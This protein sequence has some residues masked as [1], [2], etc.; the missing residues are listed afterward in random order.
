MGTG[1]QGFLKA[2][3]KGTL[4]S[5][6]AFEMLFEKRGRHL[7]LLNGVVGDMLDAQRSRLAIGM[8]LMGEVRGGKLC[9]LVH[10]LCDSEEIWR[11][12]GNPARDYGTLLQKDL[13]Y[14]PLY[15]R[16]NS[17]LHIST[18]G[19]LLSQI[20]SEI[21][22]NNPGTIR[23]IIFIGYSMGGLVVRSACHYGEAENA[24]WV[25]HVKKIF[26]LGTPHHGT[27][28]EKLG[29]LVSVILKKVPN[30]FTKAIA[31]LGNRRSAGIKDLRFGYLLD[32]DWQE[33][34]PDA[35]WRDN[36]HPVPLLKGVD[37]Y[38]ITATL[39]KKSN[40]VF[41]QYFGDGLVS[42]RS[43]GGR[44][45]MKS[46]AISFPPG[47]FKTLRGLFHMR[48][49]HHDKVYR[50][51]RKWCGERGSTQQKGRSLR[52]TGS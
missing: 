49:A 43:A 24:V 27:D 29:H 14:V 50:Q 20:L 32:E 34:D 19:R 42:S 41:I 7:S 45:F 37:Y 18:N 9:I 35:L 10:G 44:S 15:L 39:A 3:Q 12:P 22:E 25:K 23:E 36:R 51:I 47:H 52:K 31:A 17:G 21:C 33:Q 13:G 38:V 26:L 6:E 16:Y 1:F 11:F 4:V 28:L 30:I 8:R 40:N 2:I 48:L 5:L 46:K